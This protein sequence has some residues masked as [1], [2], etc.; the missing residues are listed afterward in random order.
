M[1]GG[2]A[3][4]EDYPVYRFPASR[5]TLPDGTEG[6]SPEFT[7]RPRGRSAIGGAS[8][9]WMFTDRLSIETN[10]IYRRLRLD[11]YVG[12]TVTWEFPVLAKYRFRINRF[13][14]FLEVGPSFRTTG[15]RNTEP[16]HFG[17][18]A[19]AGIAWNIGGGFRLEPTVR[20]TRWAGD[21][22]RQLFRSEPEQVEILLGLN[23]AASA[24]RNPFGHRLKLGVVGG[25]TAIAPERNSSDSSVFDGPPPSRFSFRNESQRTWI[26][27]ARLEGVLTGPLSL[28]GEANYRQVRVFNTSSFDYVDPNGNRIQGTRSGEFKQAVLWQ[29]PILLRY[30]PLKG[31][32]PVFEAGPWLRLPQEL[33]GLRLSRRG[34]T[35]G[36]GLRFDWHGVAFEPGLRLTHWGAGRF[37]SGDVGPN[38]VRRNQFDAIFAVMF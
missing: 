33:S 6:F 15:N 24:N 16:S 26:A 37:R 31:V 28:A 29:F 13:D 38:S 32:G 14:P 8:L 2:T 22:R 19:G 23:R 11:T 34:I 1:I 5:F 10:A 4:T 12:P 35:A 18:S 27:G 3:T 17:V 20:Y 25:W 30:R 21:H 36:A 7:V 9:E